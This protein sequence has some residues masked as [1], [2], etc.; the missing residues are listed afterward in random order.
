MELFRTGKKSRMNYLR[1]IREEA[2]ISNRPNAQE[3]RSFALPKVSGPK[4]WDFPVGSVQS[5]AAARAFFDAY[6]EQ[7]RKDIE[8]EFGKGS[9]GIL[10]M[11]EGLGSLA[12][13]YIVRLLRVAR[14]R[15]N[16]Y[17]CNFT[18]PTV[19]EIRR[20]RTQLGKSAE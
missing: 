10:L 9:L 15:A 3:H 17:E 7:E 11:M 16:I 8:A 12:R 5:R 20:N 14:V 19:E 13:N 2:K 18:L 1:M 6:V 4:P